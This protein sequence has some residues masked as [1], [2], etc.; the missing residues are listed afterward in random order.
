MYFYI[1][2]GIKTTS[3]K[4]ILVCLTVSMV[5]EWKHLYLAQ[6]VEKL[7]CLHLGG[8][9]NVSHKLYIGPLC[10]KLLEKVQDLN[11]KYFHPFSIKNIVTAMVFIRMY[12]DG[13]M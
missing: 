5:T 2:E 13:S 1:E 8:G 4:E 10:N 9:V 11:D 12:R 6:K 7:I 3:D